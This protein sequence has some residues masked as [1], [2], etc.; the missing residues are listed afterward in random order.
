MVTLSLRTSLLSTALHLQEASDHPSLSGTFMHTAPDGTI[1]FQIWRFHQRTPCS[2]WEAI[3]AKKTW[4]S[5]RILC[6]TT[7]NSIV[8][9][10]WFISRWYSANILI[11][12]AVSSCSRNEGL[13][14]TFLEL[15]F[16][17]SAILLEFTNF[18]NFINVWDNQF[19]KSN[20]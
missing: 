3:Q 7:I 9:S 18:C 4:Q 19:W 20:F 13:R 16:M 14:W 2:R 6:T 10:F 1:S 5:I 12:A 11:F 15:S 17:S 8:S